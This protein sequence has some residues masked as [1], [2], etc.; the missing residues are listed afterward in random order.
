MV[1]PEWEVGPGRGSGDWVR[2]ITSGPGHAGKGRNGH[3]SLQGGR[4]WR[5]VL[6]S[7]R[8]ENEEKC[9]ALKLLSQNAHL[10]ATEACPSVLFSV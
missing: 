2:G 7:L 10:S 4:L 3:D 9:R 8:E 6:N 1:G 5:E